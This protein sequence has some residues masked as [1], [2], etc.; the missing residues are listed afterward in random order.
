MIA[1][2]EQIVNKADLS[3][4]VKANPCDHPACIFVG[5]TAGCIDLRLTLPKLHLATFKGKLPP[6]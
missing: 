5:K 2:Q 6:S 1:K 4:H 3:A